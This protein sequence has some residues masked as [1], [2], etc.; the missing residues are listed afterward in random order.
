V[1]RGDVTPL[2]NQ[3]DIDPPGRD[4]DVTSYSILDP[5]RMA[6][7][8]GS[9][10]SLIRY[11]S[12]LGQP[13]PDGFLITQPNDVAR[14]AGNDDFPPCTCNAGNAFRMRKRKN[15]VSSLRWWRNCIWQMHFA[16]TRSRRCAFRDVNRVSIHFPIQLFLHPPYSTNWT[17]C[18][19]CDRQ[20][21]NGIPKIPRALEQLW[22]LLAF[23]N[24]VLF[25][26]FMNL[27][28]FSVGKYA[29]LFALLI[30]R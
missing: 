15:S 4:C 6:T 20:L 30:Y 13:H 11:G 29:G 16:A 7:S 26:R 8:L 23:L 27:T 21:A 22:T 10:G 1:F 24:S 14:T 28:I 19:T 2:G 3:Q 9:R 17:C 12:L 18:F 5:A 25:H